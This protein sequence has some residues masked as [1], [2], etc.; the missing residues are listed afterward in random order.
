MRK[1][2]SLVFWSAL[3]A[4]MPGCLWAQGLRISG[5]VTSAQDGLPIPGVNIVVKGT[6]NGVST[7]ANGNYNIAIPSSTAVLLLTSIGLIS[8]EVTVG[9]RTVVN[10]QMQESINELAQVVVTGYNTTQRKDITGSIASVSPEKFKDIPV[11]SFDQALQ[12]QAAGVQVTQSSGTPGGG[13][14]VRVRG[15]TSISASNRPLFIVDGVPVEDGNLTGRDFGG[16][17][18]NAFALFNPNDIES[19]QVLKDASAKAIYGSRAANGVVLIT[20]KRG[21]AQKT[22][23]TADVQRGLTDIVRKPDLLNASELLDLQREAVLNAGM[24]PDKLGLIKGV[25]DGQNT[26]W[27]NAVLRQGVYQQYQLS[28]QGG[29]ERT[30][31]YLSGSYR[32]EQGVQLN[33]QFTRLTGQLK[34]DHKATD[35]LSFG[36]NLTL[37][38]AFNKRVKGDNFLDGVYSGAVK[39]LPYYSPYD[40]QGNLYTPSSPEYPGFPN[41]NPVAQAVLPRFN[42]YTVKVLGGLYAEYEIIPNLRFRSKVS[43]DYNNVTEDNF[44]PSSTAI[45]GFLPSVGY[46]GYGDFSNTTISTF[47][48]TNTLTYNWQLAEKHQFNALAGFEVLQRTERGGNVQGRL[49]PS[50]DFTY[51]ASAGIVD[52]GTSSVVNSGLLSSFGEVRYNYDEKYLATLTARYDGSSRF[53]QSRRFGIFPSASLAWRLSNEPFMQQF[54]FLS[55]LKLRASYGFTGNER[56]GDFQF[57]GTWSSVTYSGATGVGPATLANPALQWE[58]TREAN[59]G[60]DASFLSGRLNLIIDAYDNLTDKLLFAQPIPQTTGFSTVQGNIGKVSNRGIELTISTVNINRAV[61]WSTDLNLSRNLNKVVELASSEPVF[62]GYQGNGVTNTNV[63]LPGQPLGTFWGLKFLGVDPATGDAIYDD[64]NGDG[65]ITPDDAQVI[66]NAQ[67]KLYG[68]LTN[69]VSWKGIDLSVLLQGSYGNSILNFS[70]VTLLNTG[71]D[72]QN[73]QVRAAL[74]RWRKEGDITSVPRYVYQNTYNNYLSSRFLEDGSY[75]RL[76]N[77]S[78]GYNLP[79]KVISKAKIANARLYVS[80]TNIL[81]WTRYTGPDPEVS[82]LDGSTTAQGIDFFTFPQIKTVVVGAT[83]GF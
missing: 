61:R 19:M 26:N 13:L 73:N 2:Y 3:L 34:L 58:R 80:A 40:E 77:V 43:I 55:D 11:A 53:G 12:G 81:T 67:P 39:S 69:K 70:N 20:T 65:R 16:Q 45:G 64:K 8:Q 37:S 54:H 44:E 71:T 25:T 35:R 52:Q 83:I 57:L 36:T 47:I 24:D 74:K 60:L 75:L 68:G 56:I 38:R 59:I 1:F 21:K 7:D 42:T 82:T 48:N 66:G 41:F 10:V 31:F 30:Q 5:R 49:F 50:D 72:I 9:N 32:D 6:T 46:Q 14:T 29:N 62:R 51:I 4:I 23:F 33:N 78:L 18:D 79:K 28:T 17:T 15:N 76:K 63:V 22:T 27:V